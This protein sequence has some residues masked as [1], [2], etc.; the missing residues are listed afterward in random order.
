VAVPDAVSDETAAQFW[1][2][3]VTVV[4]M[5]RV[6]A[7][8]KGQYLLQTAA[9]SVLGRQIIQLAR[10]LGV[11]TVNVVR[12]AALAEELAPLLG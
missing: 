11:R 1:I 2:N 6:L 7:V 12:R 4:G 3:P 9:G 8:P 5:L 10:H